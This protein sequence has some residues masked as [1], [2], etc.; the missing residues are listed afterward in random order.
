M[1]KIFLSPSTQEHN[2]Y[3]G[4]GNEETEMRLVVNAAVPYL[5]KAGYEVKVG[6]TA[7]ASA[8]V[9]E[10]NAWNPD[11]YIAVHS[12]AGGGDGTV[13]FYHSDS[14][15]GKDLAGHLQAVM[16]PLSPG[17]DDGVKANDGLIEIHGPHAP[18]ALIEVGFH[19]NAAESAWIKANE[20]TIGKALAKGIL[21]YYGKNLPSLTPAA[22]KPPAVP[23]KPKPKPAGTVQ[24]VTAHSG[25]RVR[26]GPGIKYKV[27]G[28]LK[29]GD[30]VT[31]VS[32]SA[33]WD[34]I[35]Y[36]GEYGYVSSQYTA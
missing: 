7:S 20:T 15:K 5:K 16:A 19:D 10:G 8:N 23:S 36:K 26:S 12:N 27:L 11:I 28:A 3:K 1:T 34:K 9:T 14:P 21:A 17:K 25:L 32:T 24:K 18:A 35:R 33:G 30:K 4:G 31:V 29:F 2:A 22:P 13:T 6:G